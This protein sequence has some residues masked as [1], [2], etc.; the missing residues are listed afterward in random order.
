MNNVVYLGHKPNKTERPFSADIYSYDMMKF[1]F[2]KSAR[3]S[4]A[5]YYSFVEEALR[6]GI[7]SIRCIAIYEGRAE[8]RERNQGPLTVWHQQATSAELLIEY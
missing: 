2:T 4:S 8:Q 1:Q 5:A 7:Q 3:T 6:S